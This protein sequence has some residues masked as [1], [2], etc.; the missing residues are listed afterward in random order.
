MESTLRI[1]ASL[2]TPYYTPRREGEGRA[3]EKL[4]TL[5][6]QLII[7]G[8]I[9]LHCTRVWVIRWMRFVNLSLFTYWELISFFWLIMCCLV[10]IIVQKSCWCF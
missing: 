4:S 2:S 6:N 3:W 7:Q 5:S 1:E 9:E 8:H 10:T